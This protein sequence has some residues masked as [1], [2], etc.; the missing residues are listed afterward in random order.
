METL[1]GLI[2]N[3]I[4]HRINSGLLKKGDK[5]P[6][7]RTLCKQK[8]ISMNTAIKAYNTLEDAGLIEPRPKSGYIVAYTQHRPL[9]TLVKST[10]PKVIKRANN[11]NE[12][13]NSM[14]ENFDMTETR[15]SSAL[16]S[17]QFVPIDKLNYSIRKACK[18]L[19]N[20]GVS[21]NSKESPT[22][23]TQISKRA[24]LWNG[25]LQADDIISTAGSIDALSFCLMTLT[26]K[27][28]T[29]AVE[30][31]V[32][33]GIL[34]LAHTL[35]LNVIEIPTNPVYGIEVGALEKQ[36]KQNKIK[37]CILISNFSN[38]LG[39]CIPEENKKAIVT[40]AEHYNVPIIEDDVYSD[41]FFGEKRP[42]NCKTFDESGIVLWIGSFSKTLVSG[43]RVGWLAPGKFKSEIEKTKLFHTLYT[44]TIL[45]EAV[46]LFLESG[47]Y[48]QY[49]KKVRTVLNNNCKN[50]Q[51]CIHDYFPH[52]TAFTNPQGGMNL[53]IEFS[54]DFDAL[55]LYNKAVQNK[56]SITPGR[57]YTLQNQY[58]NCIKL[59][60]G[61][62]WND[63]TEKSFIKLGKIA[64]EIAK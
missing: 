22:L 38:P 47:G 13:M 52:E 44:G 58:N 28:D 62:K 49:L 9:R 50:L 36:M 11:M 12:I 24:L 33:F 46:G 25:A 57:I 42:L 26:E 54:Q 64:K 19:N 51:H 8:S 23:K 35:G 17:P 14:M 6:S 43:Y 1:Y 2:A 60:F 16:L 18:K 55:E 53:W 20:S 10:Q 45:H 56:I 30:S 29:I 5:L 34:R 63:T 37:L 21:Y 3:D 15:L 48:E 7:L 4:E 27:G 32:W 39:C 41:L 59:S 31:P 40:L 61:M